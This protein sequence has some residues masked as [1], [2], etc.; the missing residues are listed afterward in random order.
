MFQEILVDE[1]KTGGRY[2][3]REGTQTYFGTFLG[4]Y[5]NHIK[6]YASTIGTTNMAHMYFHSSRYFSHTFYKYIPILRYQWEQYWLNQILQKITG[7]ETF[8][9]SILP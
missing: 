2:F 5:G 8:H 9:Y 6:M 7:D 4:I 3:I 1:M